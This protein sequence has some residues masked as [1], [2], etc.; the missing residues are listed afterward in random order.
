MIED[1]ELDAA[2]GAIA[3]DDARAS[4][5]H[6]PAAWDGIAARRRRVAARRQW[7]RIGI[8]A[9][10]TLVLGFGLG[11]WS[12]DSDGS[13]GA[14]IG[15]VAAWSP[16]MVDLQARSRTLLR[17]VSTVDAEPAPDWRPLASELL[18]ATRRL[19]DDPARQHAGDR[20]LLDDL[21]T[22]LTQVLELSE[23]NDRFELRLVRR[24]ITST[25]LLDRLATPA[26]AVPS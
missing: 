22:V 3:A 5:A 21:E 17:D 23:S 14:P 7:R 20:E 19:L 26:G 2:L 8:A 25:R 13:A 12:R 11:R 16:M 24:A 4:E 10:A 9:A 1:H 18:W 15:S 6:A